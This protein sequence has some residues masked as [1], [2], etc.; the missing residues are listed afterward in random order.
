MWIL[1]PHIGGRMGEGNGGWVKG[2]KGVRRY[3]FP[4]IKE[5]LWRCKVHHGSIVINNN[6]VLNIWKLLRE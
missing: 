4:V 5:M 3:K 1:S 2:M 6:T